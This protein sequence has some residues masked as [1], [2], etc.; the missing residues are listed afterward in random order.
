MQL[1]GFFVQRLAGDIYGYRTLLLVNMPDLTYIH[2]CSGGCSGAGHDKLV[3]PIPRQAY[4]V[5]LHCN[6]PHWR[7]SHDCA[8]AHV[9]TL[10]VVVCSLLRS[11]RLHHATSIYDQSNV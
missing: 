5:G 11:L 3:A 7:L 1:Q 8:L 10:A 4:V 2:V 6:L 9:S